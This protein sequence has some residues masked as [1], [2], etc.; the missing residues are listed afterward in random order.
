MFTL[1]SIFCWANSFQMLTYKFIFTLTLQSPGGGNTFP[2]IY[3]ITS[4]A[5][6]AFSSKENKETKISVK[7]NLTRANWDTCNGNTSLTHCTVYVLRQR[8][9]N[10]PRQDEGGQP[11]SSTV[12]VSA[13]K[14]N[15]PQW[16]FP[17]IQ[18]C[19]WDFKESSYPFC[20]TGSCEL[21]SGVVSLSLGRDRIGT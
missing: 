15:I 21:K 17:N 16:E 14:E 13:K 5:S 11:F 2:Q 12:H 8:M 4:I 1:P 18:K 6:I 20:S 3:T 7:S 10:I 19:I 9:Y